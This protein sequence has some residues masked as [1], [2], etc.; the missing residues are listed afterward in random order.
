[1][2]GKNRA[3]DIIKRVM[4]AV[5]TI[6]VTEKLEDFEKTITPE[7]MATLPKQ[8]DGKTL[9]IP[10]EL[11]DSHGLVQVGGGSG[12][13]V[14]ANGIVVTN[15]HVIN[16]ANAS[17]TVVTD[18]G[19]K[20]PAEILTRDPLNDVAIL[21]IAAKNLPC[22]ALGNS[23]DLDLGED[24]I[25]IGNALGLF[26]NTVSR[27]IVSGLSRS[28]SAEADPGA[29]ATEMRGLI[30][31][32]AAINPGNSGGPLVNMEGFVVGINAA[33]VAGA[34]SIGFAIPINTVK[35]DLYDLKKYGHIRRPLLGLRYVI[36]DDH[37]QEK[38]NLPSS[39]GALVMGE[40]PK[41]KGVV[42]GS[43]AY[44]AGVLEHDIVLAIDGE[45]ITRDRTVQDVLEN[46]GVGDTITLDVLRDG[47]NIELTVKL[48]ERK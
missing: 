35:R 7:V 28:I 30:Q 31:T 40:S 14:S 2:F 4:P 33:I 13:I 32:D 6:V 20:Y 10:D 45:K 43:P 11:I 24:V 18:D 34:H 1:M 29:P 9:A 23:A 17:Y 16:E 25:A 36:I 21:K 47:K 12:F 48:A 5:V 27:G 39:Y 26:K 38:T 42:P 37:L 41:D 44:D 3:V 8:A 46:L 19:R 22:L 15:K